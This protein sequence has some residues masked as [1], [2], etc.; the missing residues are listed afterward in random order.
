MEI[1]LYFTLPHAILDIQYNKSLMPRPTLLFKQRFNDRQYLSFSLFI[2]IKTRKIQEVC[3]Q[4]IK[5]TIFENKMSSSSQYLVLTSLYSKHI[6][7]S[8]EDIEI[9][10]LELEIGFYFI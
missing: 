8:F 6:L 1:F 9:I 2:K 5:N 10:R 7:N 3:T 4:N